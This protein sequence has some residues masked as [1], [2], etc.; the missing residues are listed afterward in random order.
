M[1]VIQFK[2]DFGGML[3]PQSKILSK[4]F[5]HVTCDCFTIISNFSNI[6]IIM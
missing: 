2:I 5:N 3:T 6:Q 1:Y 4:H